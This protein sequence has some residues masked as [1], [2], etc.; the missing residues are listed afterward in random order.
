MA[1]IDAMDGFIWLNGDFVKWQ[2]AKVHVLT[3]T[4]HYASSVF[5]GERAYNGKI[6]KANE[7]QARLLNSCRIMDLELNYSIE[8]INEAIYKSMEKNNLKDCYIRPL[9]FKGSEGLGIATQNKNKTQ[10]LIATWYWPALFGDNPDKGL[11]LRWADYRKPD[12]TTEPVAAKASGLYMISIIEEN[13]AIR[14]G[15][16][17]ALFKDFR[18]YI[19]ECGSSNFFLVM[20]GELHTPTTI[21]SLP[22]ITRQT[23]IEIAKQKGYKVYVRDIRP[24]EIEFADEAF[25]TGT[26]AEIMPVSEIGDK[27]FKTGKITLELRKEY[28]SLCQAR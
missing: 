18:G 5:E 17:D 1:N 21:S 20:N 12:P 26:A 15:K 28:L 24:E 16:D 10:F 4:L 3:H 19:A 14:E 13:K 6:F 22:G 27:Q 9:V 2:D 25:I 8:Q 23:T 11:K 7:H